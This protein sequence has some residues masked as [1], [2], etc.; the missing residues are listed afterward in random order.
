MKTLS[1]FRK[2]DDCNHYFIVTDSALKYETKLLQHYN[3]SLDIMCPR[4]NS[5]NIAIITKINFLS[6]KQTQPIC[7]VSSFSR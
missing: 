4:C 1:K 3:T 6:N 5:R 7:K 2:C